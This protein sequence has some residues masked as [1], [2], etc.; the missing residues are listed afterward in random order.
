[1]L[2]RYAIT[3]NL[4]AVAFDVRIRSKTGVVNRELSPR[5]DV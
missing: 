4:S 5:Y 2:A 3:L 1:M